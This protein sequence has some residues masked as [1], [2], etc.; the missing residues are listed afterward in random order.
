[1][2]NDPADKFGSSDEDDEDDDANWLGGTRFDP[3]DSD[4]GLTESN[5]EPKKFMF[6][7]HE[8]FDSV[9]SGSFGAGSENSDDVSW[10]PLGFAA[11]LI[12]D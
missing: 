7:A 4:F 12:T 6:A 2:A 9:G 3:I 5:G 11:T 1:M 8:R 10:V